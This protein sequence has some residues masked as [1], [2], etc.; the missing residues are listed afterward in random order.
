[1]LCVFLYLSQNNNPNKIKI[2]SA[3]P[4]HQHVERL[5]HTGFIELDLNRMKKM[6]TSK[7]DSANF[8]VDSAPEIEFSSKRIA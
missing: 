8:K 1:M 6:N 5:L 7:L 2:L 3:L 4:Q